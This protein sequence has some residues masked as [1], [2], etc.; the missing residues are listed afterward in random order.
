MVFFTG[1]VVTI[2]EGLALIHNH[3]SQFKEN[4]K[5]YRT[6]NKDRP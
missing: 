6:K 3:S 5:I 4:G 2:I 1:T